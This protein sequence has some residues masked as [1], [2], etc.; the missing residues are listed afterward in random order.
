MFA[1]AGQTAICGEDGSSQRPAEVSQQI[2]QACLQ[3]GKLCRAAASWS[4][5]SFFAKNV[6]VSP[7][8]HAN[9]VAAM[10]CRVLK[11]RWILST[12]RGHVVELQPEERIAGMHGALRNWPFCNPLRSIMWLPSTHHLPMDMH[13]DDVTTAAFGFDRL[14]QICVA[15]VSCEAAH[16][17]AATL[18][19]MALSN[20]SGGIVS[21]CSS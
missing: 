18:A 2:P 5:F 10:H 8:Q 11:V 4:L 15:T 13:L 3:I 6:A 1:G 19:L 21:L 17:T 12:C 7:W 9:V 16:S 20:G 14:L